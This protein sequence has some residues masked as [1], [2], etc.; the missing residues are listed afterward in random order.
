MP[1]S[2]RVRNNFK[3]IFLWIDLE[4]NK[5]IS[6]QQ[7]FID[8]Q[9]DYRLAKYWNIQLNGK[10]IPDEVFRLKTTSKTQTISSS[11]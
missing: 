2:T 5:G 6:V 10:K 1:K 11:R 8:P 9:D 4:K 3:Q 7:K